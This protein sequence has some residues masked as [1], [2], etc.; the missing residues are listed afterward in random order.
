[1]AVR[2]KSKKNLKAGQGRKKGQ[3]NKFTT[4]KQAFLD[5]FE[6][7]GGAEE[8]QRWA[9]GPLNRKD[10]YNMVTKLLPKAVEGTLTLENPPTIN[11]TFSD[12]QK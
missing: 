2:A 7:L 3:K 9:Q 4:L 12:D 5:T 1:M 10:F 8:L 6:G 11:I